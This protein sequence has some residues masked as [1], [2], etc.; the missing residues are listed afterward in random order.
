VA[1][2]PGSGAVKAGTHYD[3]SGIRTGP[4]RCY[5]QVHSFRTEAQADAAGQRLREA[6]FEA[7]NR[8]QVN[9][10]GSRWYA[11]VV[12]PFDDVERAEEVAAM[13][14]DRQNTDPILIRTPIR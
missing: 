10:D 14:R 5:I 2:R 8:L 7:A 9:D 12:G 3:S 11:V 6:G 1:E 4:L 13:L